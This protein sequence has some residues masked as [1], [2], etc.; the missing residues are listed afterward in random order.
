MKR[1]R[2][3]LVLCDFEASLKLVGLRIKEIGGDGNC[4]FRAVSD[5]LAGNEFNHGFYRE[6]TV[7]R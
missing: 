3:R 7:D 2:A 6:E 1:R 4:L 5:Q